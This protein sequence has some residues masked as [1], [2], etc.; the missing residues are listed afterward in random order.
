MSLDFLK[1]WLEDI[2]KAI[3]TFPDDVLVGQSEDNMGYLFVLKVNE[4][5]N[6]LIIGKDGQ[7]AL[8][9]RALLRAAGSQ[10]NVRA[11]LKIDIPRNK[12]LSNN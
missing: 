12:I 4:K 3:V 9:L 11:A 2:V 10:K 6:G 7:H 8:A 5:D 1:S